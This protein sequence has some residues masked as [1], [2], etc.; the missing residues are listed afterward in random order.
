MKCD[1]KEV[2]KQITDFDGYFISNYGRVFSI[3]PPTGRGKFLDSMR[4]LKQKTCSNNNYKC[5]HLFRKSRMIHRLVAREFIGECPKGF[6]V[7]HKDGNS[8]NNSLE[9]LEYSTHSE[10]V[11]RKRNHGTSKC[12]ERHHG[13]KLTKEQV[14]YIRETTHSC[15]RGTAR[16]LSK[17]FNVSEALISRIKNNTMWSY[18]DYDG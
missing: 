9:Y 1:C 17:Q 8:F 6:E 7:S 13:A 14:I 4:E 5:V 12:G 16:L 3:R 18:M 15:V 2:I 11:L 10:N